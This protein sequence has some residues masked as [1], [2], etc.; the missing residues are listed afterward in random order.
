M[1]KL[2]FSIFAIII[3]LNSFSQS[4]YKKQPALGFS[5]FLNDFQSASDIRKNGLASLIRS[6][7]LFKSNRLNEGLALQYLDGLS[8]HIDFIGT[9]G[10]SSLEYP[11]PNATTGSS[12]ATDFLF[13]TTAAINIKLLSDKYWLTPFFDVGVGASKY[14]GYFAA[15]I[16]AGVGLQV[17]LADEAYLL[18][19]S[20]YR[21][22][23]TQNANYHLYHSFTIAGNIV[24]KKVEEP[25]AVELPVVEV[26]D[27]DGD[28][29]LDS[30]DACPDIAGS[31]ALNG[32][33]DRD[34]DGIA[35][36]VDSCADVAGIA[37]YHGCPVPDTDKD[38]INDEEDKCPEVA[39]VARYQG[40]P[41]PDTDKDG[42]NDEEDKCPN[43]S[44]RA[45]NFGCPEIKQEI[46]EKVN[47]A[48][49]NI[50]FATG[51]AKLLAKSYASLNNVVKILTD[52]ASFKVD[53]DGHT[54]ITGTAEKNQVLSENR[55]ASVKAYLVSKGIDES[56]INTTGYG[57]TKPVA[58]N[59]TSAGR[60]KNRRVEIKL[61]NY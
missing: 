48:A 58:D 52:N 39:G 7:Q 22:P 61:R 26:K 4:N 45:S 33:P 20:Q 49:K 37:K 25:K 51:S 13:E 11:L 14:K 3:T 19:N 21:V 38:G 29:V 55:A 47:V 44:G 31:A 40:C 10:A 34:A 32:C 24:K 2:Y 5:F 56:R 53:V 8:N 30:L 41:V 59:K 15:F 9:L 28:G 18:F 50:F 23:V 12:S 35:D 42:V 17:N 36:N 60:S 57:I 6:K 46:I 54:D 1:K 16:P 43:E 27:R